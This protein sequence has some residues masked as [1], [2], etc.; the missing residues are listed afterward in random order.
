[1]TTVDWAGLALG[2]DTI[3]ATASGY[4][5]YT[6]IVVVTTPT[7]QV[8]NFPVTTR[9]DGGGFIPIVASDSAGHAHAPLAPTYAL[10][11]SSDTTVLKV[12]PD[13]VGVGDAQCGGGVSRIIY[14]GHG[15]ATI[16]LTDPTGVYKTFVTPPI[17]ATPVPI[18]FGLGPIIVDRTALGMQQLLSRDSVPFVQIPG[19]S[20]GTVW[21]NLRSTDPAVV[22]TSMTRFSMGEGLS[23]EIIGGDTTGTA[24]VV[25]E[26]PQLISDS[27]QVE[28]GRPAFVIRGR[29]AAPGVTDTLHAFSL[30]V[31]DHRGNRRIA[32]E[33][34]TAMISTS[35]FDVIT[36]DS[37]ALTIPAMTGTSGVSGLQ[38]F[39]GP[40]PVFLRAIDPRTI[41]YHYD[42]G[43]SVFGGP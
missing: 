38:F 40:G 4:V 8:C 23:F 42:S 41:F 15:S 9:A 36:S 5:P 37:S 1:M 27:M 16:T 3:V 17:T 24:W 7:Y 43:S 29:Q 13:T 26:G 25:A 39:G 30:E 19:Y 11:T 6:L 33:T 2:A 10:A 32:A 18:L 28:V 31:R 14:T 35:N 22:C 20:G 34:V 21:V 12:V